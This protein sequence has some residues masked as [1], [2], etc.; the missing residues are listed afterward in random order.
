MKESPASHPMNLKKMFLVFLIAVTLTVFA[1][2]L[3][4]QQYKLTAIMALIGIGLA[5]ANEPK[6]SW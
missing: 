1:I 3:V 2:S 4:T 6:N 5:I